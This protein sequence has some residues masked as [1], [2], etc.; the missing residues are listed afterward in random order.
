M[1]EE[2]VCG[3][4]EGFPVG[5]VFENRVQLSE[6]RVHRPTVAGIAGSLNHGGAD[7][8]VVSGGYEDDEDRRDVI[9]YTGHG[10]NDPNT[11]KQTSD[12]TVEASGN[13]AL[14]SN[15]YSGLPVRV[16]RGSGGD[17]ET[18]PP[19]GYRYDGLY[20]VDN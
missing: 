18:S 5:T 20:R 7:S 4:I 10:G 11:G 15:K 3:H 14:A 17:A 6:A 1:A 8:I 16:I 13:R 12:Q 9:V 19:S 2:I